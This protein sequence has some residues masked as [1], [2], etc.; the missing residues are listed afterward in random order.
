LEDLPNVACIQRPVDPL[1]LMERVGWMSTRTQEHPP[2]LFGLSAFIDRK[3]G[4][5]DGE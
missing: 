3:K 2:T 5:T 4:R 1:H